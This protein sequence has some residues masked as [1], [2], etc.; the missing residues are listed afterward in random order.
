[1]GIDNILIA[2][3][4]FAFVNRLKNGLQ[5]LGQFLILTA[6]DGKH[7]LRLLST[8]TVS[9]VVTDM[10]MPKMDGVELLATMSRQFPN[11]L[12]IVMT[13]LQNGELKKKT[14]GD[15]L[16]SY[17]NKPVDHIRLHNE[18]IRALDCRDELQ[19]KAGIYPSSLLPLV[20]IGKK[21]CRLD[22]QRN[23]GSTGT[24]I[25]KSGM[26]E[27]ASC[28][29]LKGLPALENMLKWEPCKFWFRGL[30]RQ[31][32]GLQDRI[33]LT[34]KI[35]EGTGLNADI[36]ARRETKVI[37]PQQSVRISLR[38]KPGPVKPPQPAPG[39]QPPQKTRP[40]RPPQ[41]TEPAIPPQQKK[42]VSPLQQK[43]PAMAWQQGKPAP[44]PAANGRA[45][46]PGSFSPCRVLIADASA[47]MREALKKV[48]AAD[49]SITIAGEAVNGKE[50]L[51]L[52]RQA[53]PD[54]V[55]LDTQ[56]PVMD[57][58]TALKYM[59]IQI[60]T[61]TIM[62]S[63]VT[64]EGAAVTFDTLKYGAID[65]MAKPPAIINPDM[66]SQLRTIISRVHLAAKVKIDSAK[67][68]RA[69]SAEK[70]A[71]AEKPDECRTIVCLGAAEGGYAAL[72]KIIPKLSP[73]LPVAFF[74]VLNVI[75][76]HV[77]AFITYLDRH[78]IIR[79]ARV[80]N[81][82]PVEGATCYLA[83]GREYVNI[84]ADRHGGLTML[85]QSAPSGAK[86]GY[87]I[88]T[89]M[90]SAARQ[91]KEKTIGVVLSGSGDDGTEGLKEIKRVGGRTMIQN[92]DYCLYK[93]MVENARMQIGRKM[94]YTDA[95]IA[96]ILNK[97]CMQDL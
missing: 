20:H 85:V 7:A 71:A 97:T 80:G 69:V 26:V 2:D 21:D 91:F 84:A 65:F 74:V 25:F 61:P 83:S 87:P 39:I 49:P 11:V 16:F 67:Y 5:Q 10:A 66:E 17:L 53:R 23:S 4:D 88:N 38:P 42:P 35:M 1:M 46:R 43:N 29:S 27:H 72:L 76:Q 51:E 28:G 95:K 90:F 60:P 45:A 94:I 34:S 78:S 79:I 44:S 12:S 14:T 92:P 89:L 50:A 36:P 32:P 15:S 68:I 48:L 30:P 54:V 52:I 40:V 70:K 62:F 47:V 6:P 19:F 3:D 37:K 63:A 75:P 86:A 96:E 81:G 8:R 77:D 18:I 93:E 64:I 24:L 58:F 59:M 41:Q 56:L 57:G 13:S 33:G 73:D 22:I 82:S 55:I 9:L 31:H